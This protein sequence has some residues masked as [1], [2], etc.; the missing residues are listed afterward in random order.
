MVVSSDMVQILSD[1]DKVFGKP[2]TVPDYK[3]TLEKS[4]YA[5]VSEEMLKFFAGAID[6]NN[7]IGEPVNRYRH[8]YPHKFLG[9]V[10]YVTLSTSR[11]L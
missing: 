10:F 7:V 4:M 11:W 8:R 3:Y 5:A 2:Q 6:F 1:D 9:Q